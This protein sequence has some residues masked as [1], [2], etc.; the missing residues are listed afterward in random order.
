[1]SDFSDTWLALREPADRRARADA[2]LQGPAPGSDG[3]LEVLDLGCGTGANL[4]HLFPRLAALGYS[5]QHWT[6]VDH[7][8]RL[9]R[10]LRAR[11][12]AWATGA[13]YGMLEGVGELTV[14]EGERRCVA[15]VLQTDLGAAFA[16]P[17]REALPLDP[18]AITT[19]P[20]RAPMPPPDGLVTA[21]ALLDLV[22]EPWLKQ[23][24]IRC[25]AAR[26]RLLFALSYDGRC[27]LSPTH[28]DDR[29]VIDLVNRHQQTDKGLGAALGPFAARAAA[30]ECARLGYR[31]RHARSDWH[32]VADEALLQRALLDGWLEAATEMAPALG[33][34]LRRWRSSR[35]QWL[36]A[37]DSDISVGHVDLWAEPMTQTSQG[38]ETP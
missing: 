24:L 34:R 4:R 38:R 9:L 31:V 15:R 11:T 33:E 22:S 20:E 2:L 26:C 18:T 28:E 23:F 25:R 10:R 5:E 30:A 6:C 8:P 14:T 37:G 16:T 21:S 3:T 32:I 12:R 7:D 1:M 27:T 19:Q 13:G 36:E 17:E 35:L 29:L